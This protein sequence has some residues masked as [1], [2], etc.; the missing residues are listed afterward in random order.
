MPDNLVS[1]S[2]QAGKDL[3]KGIKGDD[4]KP[5]EN[6]DDNGN[7]IIYSNTYVGSSNDSDEELKKQCLIE[8]ETQAKAKFSVDS[9]AY[10][11]LSQDI[12][13]TSDNSVANCKVAI[14]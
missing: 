4:D 12:S 11:V 6:Q 8:L 3:Y 7:Y 13:K 14:L 2:V 1:D 9:L 10:K 5:Q